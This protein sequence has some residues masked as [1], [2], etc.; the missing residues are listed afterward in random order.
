DID[1]SSLERDPGLRK[2][3][4]DYPV[5]Q[6]D[7]I[8]RAY[9]RVG[10][11]QHIMNAIYSVGRGRKKKDDVTMDHHYRIDIFV[12]AIES[13]LQELNS[14]FDENMVELIIHSSTLDPK[15]SFK[16]FSVDK[17]C[18]LVSKFY[19]ED[20][21]EQEQI[22]LPYELQHYAVDIFQH[23]SFGS[24]FTLSE[25]CQ[26]LAETG[27]AVIYPLVDRLIRLVLT[28]PVSTATTERAFSAMN[29]I[30]NKLRSKMEDDYLRSSL[31]LYIGREIAEK[32]T[33]DAIIDDFCTI[34]ER[35]VRFKYINFFIVHLFLLKVHILL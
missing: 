23:P 31:V 33:T 8:R 18:S 32:I 15:D 20:F 35:R 34:K 14:R 22:R 26:R 30:K 12:A 11:Y 25:L 7:E 29:I 5:N 1:L 6:R 4:Y 17:I 9:L 27:K 19:P 3:I 16:S 2:Q 13:Q 24:I 28:L 21:T 10:P